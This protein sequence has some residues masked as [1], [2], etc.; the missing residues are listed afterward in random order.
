MVI[1]SLLRNLIQKRQRLEQSAMAMAGLAIRLAQNGFLPILPSSNLAVNG[2]YAHRPSCL[3]S[4][5]GPSMATLVSKEGESDRFLVSHRHSDRAA[6]G[7][8]NRMDR[9]YSI[10]LSL[11]PPNSAS[12]RGKW[13]PETRARQH[14]AGRPFLNC[15]LDQPLKRNVVPRLSIRCSESSQPPR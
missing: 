8:G 7:L 11:M 2:G 6:V 5:S 12:A 14:A 15:F 1:Q 9:H 13:K 10:R 3:R 4:R